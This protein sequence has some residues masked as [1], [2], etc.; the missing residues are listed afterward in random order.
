MQS[1]MQITIMHDFQQLS[2][3]I[4]GQTN[5]KDPKNGNDSGF[6]TVNSM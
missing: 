6:V 3:I 1:S 2:L 5:K 4:F